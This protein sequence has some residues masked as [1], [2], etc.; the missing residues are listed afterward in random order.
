MW[1]LPY[2]LVSVLDFEKPS[3]VSTDIND[4][5]FFFQHEKKTKKTLILANE[6]NIG[7]LRS[8]SPKHTFL[9]GGFNP[10]EKY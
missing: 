7:I 4:I 1:Y 5:K 6:L 8:Q 2:Q 9:V 10:F 3:T